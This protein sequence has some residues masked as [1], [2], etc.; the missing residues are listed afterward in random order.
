MPKNLTKA[1]R[2]K[3]RRAAALII[4]SRRVKKQAL[5]MK[6]KKKII[7]KVIRKRRK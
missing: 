5:K 4:L 3:L 1:G 7:R 2:E 6:I